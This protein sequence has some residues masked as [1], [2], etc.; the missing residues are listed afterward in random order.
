MP[1]DPITSVNRI[2]R[3]TGPDEIGKTSLPGAAPAGFGQMLNNA[4]NR[5]NQTESAANDAVTRLAA[6]EDIDLHQVMLT[7]QEADLS[8]QLALQIRNKLVEAYQDVMRM[9]V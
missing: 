5:L 3:L 6:G 7:M 1:I 8:F 4:L 9:Q 2:G